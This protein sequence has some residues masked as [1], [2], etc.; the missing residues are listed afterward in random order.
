M[1]MNGG[2]CIIAIPT[3]QGFDPYP[4]GYHNQ[5]TGSSMFNAFLPKVL[6]KIGWN[7]LSVSF[8]GFYVFFYLISN[9]ISYDKSDRNTITHYD[10]S[11]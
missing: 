10:A 7:I 4:Y 1:V 8:L 9:D 6:N 3:L 5:K 2:W 11:W